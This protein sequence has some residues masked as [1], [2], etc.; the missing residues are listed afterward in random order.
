MES[1]SPNTVNSVRAVRRW[2]EREREKKVFLNSNYS[3]GSTA[4]CSVQ[5][6]KYNKK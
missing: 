5:S 3:A 6:G 4:L 2:R 1:L